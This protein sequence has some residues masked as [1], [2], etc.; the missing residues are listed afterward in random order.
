MALALR[1]TDR[2]ST[3]LPA[4]AAWAFRRHEELVMPVVRR[5][6]TSQKIEMEG[7]EGRYEEVD[8]YIVLFETYHADSDVRDLLRG[9][10]DDRCQCPHWGYVF[11]GKQVFH[12]AD[13]D[14]VI[15]AGQA[16]YAPPGHWPEVFAGTEIVEFSPI[17]PFKQAAEVVARNLQ[18][19][20]G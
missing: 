1:T 10:P 7:Y 17:E 8:G 5:D 11:A 2:R 9:L 12:Y 19:D 18:A 3:R 20:S 13:R 16:Y 14:E 15:T 4:A 6:S